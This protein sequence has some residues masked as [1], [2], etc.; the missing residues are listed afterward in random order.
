MNAP[1]YHDGKILKF[2]EIFR[3]PYPMP[4]KEAAEAVLN[5]IRSQHSSTYGRVEIDAR[6][7]PSEN[8][9]IAVRHHA[10]YL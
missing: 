2:E 8:G 3:S 1:M 5:S 4:T 6:I 7:E 10:Q 9:F